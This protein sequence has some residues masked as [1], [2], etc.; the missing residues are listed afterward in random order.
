MSDLEQAAKAVLDRWDSPTWEWTSQGPTA[1]LMADL[2]RAL[3]AHRA[4]AEPVA[5]SWSPS[6]RETVWGDDIMNAEVEIDRD[7]TLS[8]YCESSQ[9]R[10][11]DAMFSE[12][13]TLRDSCA[14]KADRIDRLGEIVERLKQ[15]QAEPVS[16][17]PKS[18][19]VGYMTGYAD[20]QR[21][22]RE[23]QQAEPVQVEPVVQDWDLL[24]ETQAALR[25]AWAILKKLKTVQDAARAL[26]E[27]DPDSAADTEG[28][29]FAAWC[30]LVAAIDDADTLLCEF[31]KSHE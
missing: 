1:V 11:V 20:G 25:D 21:E 18:F 4:Q 29:A 6:P 15:Q 19:R 10:A 14:A 13:E 31:G 23:K 30:A 5:L 12:I 9:T 27:S 24:S 7:H 22:L 3:A 8:L 28:E 26:V 16:A 17:P 2:R